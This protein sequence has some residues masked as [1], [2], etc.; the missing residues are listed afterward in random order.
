MGD[1]PV[2]IV[3]QPLANVIAQVLEVPVEDIAGLVVLVSY[4][5]GTAGLFHN[6][7]SI[8][9]AH[10]FADDVFTAVIGEY[11]DHRTV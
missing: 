10:Q 4:A 1:A 6:A 2:P 7:P 11:G 9:K 5:D 8:R 3:V